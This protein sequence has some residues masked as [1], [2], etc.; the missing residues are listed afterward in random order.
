[1]RRLQV[2]STKRSTRGWRSLFQQIERQGGPTGARLV[3][4]AQGRI[5]AAGL[6]HPRQKVSHENVTVRQQGVGRIGGRP[7]LARRELDFRAK[8]GGVG[9]E[10]GPGGNALEAQQ[11]LVAGAGQ[12]PVG[13]ALKRGDGRR[14][15]LL[16]GVIRSD[17]LQETRAVDEFGGHRVAGAGKAGRGILVSGVLQQSQVRGSRHGGRHPAAKAPADREPSHRN[18]PVQTEEHRRRGDMHA[19]QQR[20]QFQPMRRHRHQHLW[21]ARSGSA[22]FSRVRPRSR[23]GRRAPARSPLAPG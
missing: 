11:L 18:A 20:H 1:M 15:P 22:T 3:I 17:T 6:D 2:R 8:G 7:T 21:A 12:R 16:A 19:A 23:P 4:K 9:V 13:E 5:E 14:D 10:I